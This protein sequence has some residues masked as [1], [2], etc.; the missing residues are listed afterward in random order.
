MFRDYDLY[1]V[2]DEFIIEDKDNLFS[3][4]KVSILNIKKEKYIFDLTDDEL[5]KN[6]FNLRSEFYQKRGIDNF[7]KLA[8]HSVNNVLSKTKI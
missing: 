3:V 6:G 5:I 8:A 4:E 7:L 1:D 2:S